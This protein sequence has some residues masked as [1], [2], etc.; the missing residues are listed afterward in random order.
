M[1]PTQQNPDLDYLIEQIKSRKKEIDRIQ[2]EIDSL[3]VEYSEKV[4]A[5]GNYSSPAGTIE[6]VKQSVRTSWD[7]RIVETVIAALNDISPSLSA[8]LESA[9]KVTFV[10]A[11]WRVK[12]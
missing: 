12:S 1:N 5:Q 9:K 7:T 11:T 3:R 10:G 6:V 8:Q 4:F 2:D